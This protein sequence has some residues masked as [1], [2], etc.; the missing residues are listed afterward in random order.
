MYNVVRVENMFQVMK[1]VYREY[2]NGKIV[3]GPTDIS[4]NTGM[5]K[6]T[7]HHALKEL[8]K[9]GYGKYIEKKGFVLNEYGIKA[10]R[11]IMRRHRL[12]ECFIVA[13]LSLPPEKACVEASKIDAIVGEDFMESIERKYGGRKRCPCG[14]EIPR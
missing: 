12:L 7:A 9:N 6:S 14:K 10:A 8:A 13:T 4:K 11:K 3:V 1:E 2:E 5:A